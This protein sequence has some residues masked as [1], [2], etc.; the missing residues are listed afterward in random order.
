[1]GSIETMR[2]VGA[3]RK[4]PD[5]AAL[6][7]VD[8]ELPKPQLGNNDVL[9]EVKAISV[10]PLDVRLAGRQSASLD[11]PRILGWDASGTVTAVGR[12]VSDLKPGDDVFYAGDIRRPGCNA[13]WQAVDAHLVARK[14][15]SMSFTTAACLSL[16]GLTAWQML[17]DLFRIDRKAVGDLLVLGGAGGVATM[18]VQLAKARTRLN[19]IATASRAMSQEW[20]CRI[21]ADLVISHEQPLLPQIPTA[22]GRGVKYAFSMRTGP[23]Q[24]DW[25]L[26]VAAPRGKIG[27]IDTACSVDLARLREK[28]LSLFAGSVWTSLV[29]GSPAIARHGGT[30]EKLVTLFEEGQLADP[31]TTRLKGLSAET[32]RQAHA[33]IASGRMVGKLAIEF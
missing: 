7:L 30:L 6:A 9:V 33:E 3:I 10:N 17:F 32:I 27:F 18:A 16:V 5:A 20:L 13:Q 8:L 19:I 4:D 2:A 15:A 26:E 11:A 24:F 21:G 28:S 12:N 22:T 25:L 29:H 23:E 31:V 1:M 14:P